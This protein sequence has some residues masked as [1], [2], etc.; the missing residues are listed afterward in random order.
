MCGVCVCVWEDECMYFGPC[1][2]LV[3][4]KRANLGYVGSV[5]DCIPDTAMHI[6][7]CTLKLAAQVQGGAGGCCNEPVG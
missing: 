1:P 5:A 4:R 3:S 6:H 7:G 2:V